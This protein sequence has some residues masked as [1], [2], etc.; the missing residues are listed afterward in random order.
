MQIDAKDSISI[1][2]L[3][4]PHKPKY[5]AIDLNKLSNYNRP[6]FAI[7]NFNSK[8]RDWNCKATNKNER[9]LREFIVI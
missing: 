4:T 6:T 9:S 2:F 1:N 5:S 3:Y 8:Q 7:V